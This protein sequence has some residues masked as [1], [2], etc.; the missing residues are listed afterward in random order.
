MSRYALIAFSNSSDYRARS[1]GAP[2]QHQRAGYLR[3]GTLAATMLR[4]LGGQNRFPT[5]TRPRSLTLTAVL[6]RSR[7]T[8][9]AASAARLTDLSRLP[10]VLGGPTAEIRGC[11]YGTPVVGSR[12]TVTD[13]MKK[14]CAAFA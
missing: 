11:S 1:L 5:T 12:V 9:W 14:R 6:P 2:E 7:A 4:A 13:V 10:G 3:L 8:A